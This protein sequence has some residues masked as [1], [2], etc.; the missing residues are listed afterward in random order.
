M[1][2]G[3]VG[4]IQG[5]ALNQFSGRHVTHIFYIVFLGEVTDILA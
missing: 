5:L 2:N 1:K 4:L 3:N